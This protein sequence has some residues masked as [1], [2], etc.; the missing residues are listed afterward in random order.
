MWYG[1]R[2]VVG[3]WSLERDKLAEEK[4]TNKAG[5]A[6]ISDWWRW[7]TITASAFCDSLGKER[8]MPTPI[9]FSPRYLQGSQLSFIGFLRPPDNLHPHLDNW[10]ICVQR[11]AVRCVARRTT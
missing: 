3:R 11:P 6:N 4:R 2:L 8:P 7:A 9:R 10:E 5:A 1:G